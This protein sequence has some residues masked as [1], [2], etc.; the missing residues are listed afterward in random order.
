LHLNTQAKW[1]L[2]LG[3]KFSIDYKKNDNNKIF[4]N[5]NSLKFETRLLIT[6]ALYP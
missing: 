4:V 2:L 3:D 1:Y 5:Y 6:R